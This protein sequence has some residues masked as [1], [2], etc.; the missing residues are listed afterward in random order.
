ML[1]FSISRFDNTEKCA[2]FN[3]I[4]LAAG[5]RD[6]FRTLSNI[7]DVAGFQNIIED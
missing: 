4:V 6:A 5:N 3:G 7:Y 1:I 2:L